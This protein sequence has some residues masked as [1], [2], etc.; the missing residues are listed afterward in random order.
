MTHH[1]AKGLEWPVVVLLD[2]HTDVKDNVWSITA[3]SR[4][5]IQVTD[6]LRDRFIR[7]WPWPFG[8][9]KTVPLADEIALSEVGKAFRASAIEESKRLLYVSM[10]R[11]RDLLVLARSQRKLSGEWLDTLG[12]PWL[13]PADEQSNLVLPSGNT[14]DAIRWGLDPVEIEGVLGSGAEVIHWYQTSE[15]RTNRLPLVLNPSTALPPECLVAEQVRVGERIGVASGTDMGS[16]GSAIHACI[17]ASLTDRAAPLSLEDVDLLLRGFD[18]EGSVSAK[19]ILSQ[20][21]ALHDWISARWGN[22]AA[23]AEI[24]VEAVTDASQIIQG[25]IDL[26]LELAGGWI[27]IDHKSNPRGAEQWESIAKDYAGQLAT[28]KG[29]VERATG[30][31]VLE[32]WLFFPVAAGAVRVKLLESAPASEDVT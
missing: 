31:P 23:F 13:L 2:L 9:Q 25:R 24:P 22:A 5:G 28:Y 6:P 7:Y 12:A 27:L 19:A 18:V 3:A 17:A 8:A 11:A 26:L 4:S 1:G 15:Q 29:A 16:L 21:Q 32:S 10:T 20:V 30:K 14:I